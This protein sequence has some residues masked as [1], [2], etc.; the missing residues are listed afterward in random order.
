MATRGGPVH[1]VTTTRQYKGRVY[2]AHL[3]R[4]SFRQDGKVLISASN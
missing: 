2:S 1:V 3:L 4:R